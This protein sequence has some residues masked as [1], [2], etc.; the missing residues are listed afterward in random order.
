MGCVEDDLLNLVAWKPI[1]V[2]AKT[3]KV[4][5]IDPHP[6]KVNPLRDIWVSGSKPLLELEWDL[7]EWWWRDA[8]GKM[9]SFFDYSVKL[10]RE[11]QQRRNLAT[12][13]VAKAWSSNS[14][15]MHEVLAFSKW[16]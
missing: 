16:L 4:C 11:F 8:N 12:L 1:R 9:V 10:G 6:K 3:R 13:M 15:P 2:V 14:I 7:T 5:I